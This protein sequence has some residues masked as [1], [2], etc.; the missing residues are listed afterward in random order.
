LVTVFLA[1]LAAVLLVPLLGFLGAF[2]LM[3]VF[4]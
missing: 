3:S 1:L 2:F 4:I